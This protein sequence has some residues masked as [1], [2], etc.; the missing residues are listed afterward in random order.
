MCLDA[1]SLLSVIVIVQY[2]SSIIFVFF[3]VFYFLC[4]A[5]FVNKLHY[6][7]N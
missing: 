3:S 4:Y 1:V 7:F 6:Y 5:R 2:F